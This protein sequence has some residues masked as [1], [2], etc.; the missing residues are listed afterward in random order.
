MEES[1][2]KPEDIE[3]SKLTGKAR[4]LA[5]LRLFKKG[6]IHNP[7]GRPKGRTISEIIRGKLDKV[8]E[9]DTQT[10]KRTWGEVIAAKWLEDAKDNARYAETLVDRMEG[11]PNQSLD[12]KSEK[13]P[14]FDW[15]AIPLETRI[16]I[17][18]LLDNAKPT[19]NGTA[20]TGNPTANGNP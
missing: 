2:I 19:D 8:C 3:K 14:D 18:K 10:P 13:K 6:E 12:V 4:R 11:K 7:K 17:L 20:G 9:S 5:N 1:Q 16:Q 15:K